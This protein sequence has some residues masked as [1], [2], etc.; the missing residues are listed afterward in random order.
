[1]SEYPSDIEQQ[2]ALPFEEP[3]TCEQ[4]SVSA[5][6]DANSVAS[7]D[8]NSVTCQSDIPVQVGARLKAARVSQSLTLEAVS[9][10][11]RISLYY[12]K[13]LEADKPLPLSDTFVKGYIRNYA[14]CLQI[15]AESLLECAGLLGSRGVVK[16]DE[17]ATDTKP[18]QTESL[19]SRAR[20][21]LLTAPVAS[22][23]LNHSSGSSW[24]RGLINSPSGLLRAA[25]TTTLP[26][27]CLCIVAFA[28]HAFDGETD[29]SHS[30]A[31]IEQNIDQSAEQ[32]GVLA[33]E[34]VAES[35]PQSDLPAASAA[36]AFTSDELVASNSNDS[37]L[38]DLPEPLLTSH[39]VE[40]GSAAQTDLLA[41]SAHDSRVKV[42]ATSSN[43]TVKRVRLDVA[44]A[45]TARSSESVVPS[46]NIQ[47]LHE[48]VG[49]GAVDMIAQLQM[50]DRLVI[51]V[52]ED[53][54]VDVRDS[55]GS[56]LYRDLARAGR[57]IDVSGRLPF[58]LHVGNAPG[59]E[60]ELNGE[61]VEITRYRS[62]NSAR[63]T[64]A[65]NN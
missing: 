62:D 44:A 64:L 30:V 41:E 28:Y 18:V 65:S 26:L 16:S 17:S 7:R 42:L 25:T 58:S 49:P 27:L 4:V 12:L 47:D 33:H 21:L 1:M 35:A 53:S 31:A 24:S 11:T 23:S 2:V 55:S 63:L 32:I 51:Q 54:W 14:S 59:L 6:G 60:L 52:Y 39:A 3:D 15:N 61:S 36:E 29:T 19:F 8:A 40:V 46:A 48:P 20:R 5:C 13:L 22:V 45:G 43:D 50:Q 38:S 56:R 57:K 9:E 10:Q 37:H 34:A